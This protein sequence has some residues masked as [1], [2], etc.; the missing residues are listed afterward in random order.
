MPYHTVSYR[1]KTYHTVLHLPYRTFP[2]PGRD[3]PYR[4]GNVLFRTA[5]F[6]TTPSRTVP[7]RTVPYCTV[8]HLTVPHSTIPYRTVPYRVMPYRTTPY[9]AAQLRTSACH[10]TAWKTKGTS[11]AG[12][13]A[14]KGPKSLGGGETESRRSSPPRRSMHLPSARLCFIFV[15]GWSVGRFSHLEGSHSAT[16]WHRVHCKLT[17]TLNHELS[18][19]V[20]RSWYTAATQPPS[21]LL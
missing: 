2:V 19:R 17:L 13:R 21:H 11:R 12:H 14:Q 10:P 1:A 16:V 6:R 18:Y 3:G 8:A 15:Y 20:F 4:A 5:L 9:R 7:Y